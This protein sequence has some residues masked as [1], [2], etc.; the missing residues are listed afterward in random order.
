MVRT[1]IAIDIEEP[2]II[3]KLCKIQKELLKTGAQMKLVERQNLHITL[4]FLGEISPERI[5]L[6]EDAIIN[7]CKGFTKFQIK[8]EGLGAFPSISYPR[9]VW[10][11][12]TR[13][14][15]TLKALA[16]SIEET[17]VRVGFRKSDKV[18]H[19]HVTLARIKFRT[20]KLS[21]F[22][23]KNRNIEVGEKLVANVRIKKSILRPQ[24]PIYET[25]A[26]IPL[27]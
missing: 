11:G 23:L 5:K 20:P 10:V 15:E 18:F 16:K 24:G 9:V 21:E 25:L 22:I 12:V 14:S 27:S 17:T 3:E 6:L 1:F 7:A 26:E 2:E 13:G 8:L 19:P 4:K